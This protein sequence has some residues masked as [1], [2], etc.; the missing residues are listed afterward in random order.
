[1]TDHQTP[2]KKLYGRKKVTSIRRVK[3][4]GGISNEITLECKHVYWRPA[5]RGEPKSIDCYR[6][7]L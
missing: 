4:R 7:K 2:E 5:S 6:C 1:M 3:S